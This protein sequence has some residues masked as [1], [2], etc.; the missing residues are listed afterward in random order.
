MG[1]VQGF[2]PPL[3]DTELYLSLAREA[4]EPGVA[5]VGGQRK[6]KRSLSGVLYQILTGPQNLPEEVLGTSKRER[7]SHP[8]G[9]TGPSG[10]P[11]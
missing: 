8:G 7:P 2:K 4:W 10:P 6:G 9:L 11:A 5:L 1:M 3:S